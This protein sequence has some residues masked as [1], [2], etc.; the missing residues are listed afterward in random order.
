LLLLWLPLWLLVAV[1]GGT[2]SCSEFLDKQQAAE[3]LNLPVRMIDRLRAE[4]R[5]PAYKMGRHLRFKR[6]DLD[7]W[8]EG[9]RDEVGV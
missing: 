8:A 2:V 3:Y 1:A 5:V 9:S 4:R 6:A 7:A